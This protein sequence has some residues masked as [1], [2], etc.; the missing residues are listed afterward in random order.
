MQTNGKADKSLYIRQYTIRVEYTRK[1]LFLVEI[2]P[3]TQKS[4]QLSRKTSTYKLQTLH[5]QAPFTFPFNI[6]SAI[7]TKANRQ[8][9]ITGIR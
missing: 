7:R 3:V 8:P 9:D 6:R 2:L 4:R 1:D 5:L